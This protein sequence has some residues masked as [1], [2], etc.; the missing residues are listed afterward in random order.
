MKNLKLTIVI[1]IVS[2]VSLE[3]RS[4]ARLRQAADSAFPG[5][6]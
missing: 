3:L 4:Q 1:I 5:A 6:A 2:I